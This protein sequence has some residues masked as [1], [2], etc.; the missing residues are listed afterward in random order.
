MLISLFLLCTL[1]WKLSSNEGLQE[2]K[3]SGDVIIGGLLPL[4]VRTSDDKCG[5]FFRYGLDYV[6][7]MTYAINR[8]NNDVTILPNITIGYHIKDFCDSPS[9][10]MKG[11]YEFATNNT[12]RTLAD[13]FTKVSG[14]VTYDCR[15]GSKLKSGDDKMPPTSAIIGPVDSSSCL[16]VANLL[17]VVNIPVITPFAT[18]EELSDGLGSFFRTVPS[19]S[20]Q[21]KA[22]A[23]IID[24]FK[25]EYVAVVAVDHS[26]GRYGVRALERESF[27]RGTFC[28]AVTEFFPSSG[29]EEKI[30]TIIR[31][32]KRRPNIQ[33]VILWSTY[34]P[35]LGVLKEA[36]RQHLHG[37]AWLISEGVAMQGPRFFDEKE[38]AVVDGFI[39]IVHPRFDEK[40]F[41][42]HLRAKE[43]KTE[44]DTD[45]GNPWWSEYWK[46]R[47]SQN[48][49][50]VPYAGYGHVF[51]TPTAPSTDG[52][53]KETS[54]HLS[55]SSYLINAVYAIAHALDDMYRCKNDT[56]RGQ[57]GCP[58][59]SPFI[60]PNDLTRYIRNVEFRRLNQSVS[61]NEHGDPLRSS[62]DVINFQ[63]A[64][65]SQKGAKYTKIGTWREDASRQLQIDDTLVQWKK[66]GIEG[67]PVS[68]CRAPCPPGTHQTTAV[69]CCWE[70]IPCQEGAVNPYTG[71]PNCTACPP[72]KKSNTKRTDCVDLPLINIRCEDPSGVVYLI[73][74]ILGITAV[75]WVAWVFASYKHTPVVKSASKELCFLLL[76][77]IALCFALTSLHVYIPSDVIC[78]IIQPG[79]YLSHTFSVSVLLVKTNRVV[80]LF[81]LG[82]FAGWFK[83]ISME[84]KSQFLL[85]TFLNGVQIAF[86]TM[87]LTLDPPRQKVKV[88]FNSHMWYTCAYLDNRMHKILEGTMLIYLC[89]ISLF[90]TFYAFKAR[91]LPENYNETR[92]IGFAM[93]ILIISWVTSF[94]VRASLDG[95]YL[96]HIACATSLVSAYGILV[97]MFAPK[98]YIILLHPDKNTQEVVKAILTDYSIRSA[99]KAN[100]T[101]SK[102]S[103]ASTAQ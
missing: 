16:L 53:D 58:D 83:R 76:S 54:T 33:V 11:A 3:A 103:I 93:Y 102:A 82:S 44:Q 78:M 20:E 28:L 36:A 99:S 37:R 73:L 6:E 23:D 97:C 87:W 92:Y 65:G 66:E 15:N 32:L 69:S 51:A 30:K 101:G 26:Y 25:W 46:L 4:H 34:T 90:C 55:Y 22:M 67:V 17:D 41:V 45:P 79:K 39:G 72:L 35:G 80:R 86:A 42:Q 96:T 89:F 29:Y 31:N 68:V 19:D 2:I 38:A 27:A 50:L 95:T 40:E 88:Q 77:S 12:L 49:T 5:A 7:A 60:D 61:F 91:K 47:R 64:P 63:L 13:D 52:K 62:Y 10:A 71:S 94:P 85:L 48:D 56:K 21:A 1:F 84:T 59:L 75:I 18:S 81:S 70:C 98:L 14:N 57:K 74:S 43:Q 9:L 100:I 24:Y 8:I